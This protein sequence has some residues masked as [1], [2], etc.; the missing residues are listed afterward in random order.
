MGL[1]LGQHLLPV[2][3]LDRGLGKKTGPLPGQ[4]LKPD[5][6]LPEGLMGLRLRHVKVPGR[7]G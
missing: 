3:A 7:C 5:D 4:L 1:D 6:L 2:L